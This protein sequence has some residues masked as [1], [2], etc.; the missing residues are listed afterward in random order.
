MSSLYFSFQKLHHLLCRRFTGKSDD[1]LRAITIVW[2]VAHDDITL[3]PAN[4]L[5]DDSQFH[6]VRMVGF[7]IKVNKNPLRRGDLF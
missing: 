1:K 4:S 7:V 3:G 2:L 6:V 5:L